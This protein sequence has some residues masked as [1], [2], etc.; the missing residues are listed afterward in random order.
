MDEGDVWRERCKEQVKLSKTGESEE[1]GWEF[2][3]VGM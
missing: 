1:A 3:V 2:G